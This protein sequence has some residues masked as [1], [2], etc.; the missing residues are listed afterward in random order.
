MWRLLKRAF[1]R[2]IPL[3][4]SSVGL[5]VLIMLL[6]LMVRMEPRT[7]QGVPVGITDYPD[8][9]FLRD[10]WIPP[11][12]DLAMRGPREI[13]DEVKGKISVEVSLAGLGAGHHR[14][15][16]TPQNVKIDVPVSHRK[17]VQVDSKISDWQVQCDL[18]MYARELPVA[19][20]GIQGTPEP[21]YYCDETMLEVS[22][23]KI[24]V[25]APPTTLNQLGQE[26]RQLPLQNFAVKVDGVNQEV[27]YRRYRVLFEALKVEPV[28]PGDRW[29]DVTIHLERTDF[30]REIPVED[31][32]VRNLSEGARS[33]FAT[34]EKIMATIEGRKSVIESLEP[35]QVTA[36]LDASLVAGATDYVPIRYEVTAPTELGVHVKSWKPDTIRLK[37]TPESK[38]RSEKK[39]SGD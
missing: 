32:Q 4:L 35:S 37:V 34:D 28:F 21:P 30:E 31:V 27:V 22:P 5:A 9:M 24:M 23:S 11:R 7:F 33:S 18:E 38:P 14:I 26:K 6:I 3:K 10:D 36:W 20:P 16:L 12:I 15:P 29:V 1:T 25:T 2:D 19:R 13:L 17:R 39:P 8:N